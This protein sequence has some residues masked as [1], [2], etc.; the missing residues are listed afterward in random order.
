V[1]ILYDGWPLAHAGNSPA[2]V[3]LLT[4]LAAH[5][6]GIPAAVVLPGPTLHTLPG[7]V[8]VLS[9]QT[10]DTPAGRLRW[11][12][13]RL[14]SLARRCG[15]THVHTTGGPALFGTVAGLLSPAGF[16]TPE[17]HSAGFVNRLGA[18]LAHGGASRLQAWLW[19]ADLPAES[20]AESAAAGGLPPAAQRR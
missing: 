2:A 17:Q 10:P 5:P 16:N 3:H 11:E 15:A 4:L 13:R 19:P 1:K 6:S 14:P 7:S 8:V 9:V 12:Q 20:A 18:A